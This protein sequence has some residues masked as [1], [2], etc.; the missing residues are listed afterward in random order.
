MAVLTNWSVEFLEIMVG[1]VSQTAAGH[2][3]APPRGF[4]GGTFAAAASPSWALAMPH[5]GSLEPWA[6]PQTDLAVLAAAALCLSLPVPPVPV[7]L[8]PA[9]PGRRRWGG[10]PAS[11]ACCSSPSFSNNSL[12]F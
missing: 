7:A 12:A 11:G 10:G 3:R 1:S 5:A 6:G 9:S 2:P 8:P 4:L